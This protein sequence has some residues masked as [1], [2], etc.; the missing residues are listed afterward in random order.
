MLTPDHLGTLRVEV[1]HGEWHV[2]TLFRRGDGILYFHL[3][4]HAA[5]WGPHWIA[6]GALAGQAFRLHDDADEEKGLPA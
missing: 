2:A 5:A 3:T 1:H 4:A 6:L